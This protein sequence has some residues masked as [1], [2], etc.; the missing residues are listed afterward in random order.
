[1]LANLSSIYIPVGLERRFPSRPVFEVHIFF[2]PSFPFDCLSLPM[3]SPAPIFL[4]WNFP[5]A[6]GRSLLHNVAAIVPGMVFGL[7]FSQPILRI[8]WWWL[9]RFQQLCFVKLFFFSHPQVGCCF[10]AFLQPEPG[11]PSSPSCDRRTFIWI[12]SI[13]AEWSARSAPQP[14]VFSQISLRPRVFGFTP[15]GFPLIVHLKKC[16]GFVMCNTRKF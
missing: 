1:M 7:S 4:V 13:W 8:G 5:I 2:F 14:H 10:F 15:R 6:V 9:L 12:L 11:C 16:I 3:T